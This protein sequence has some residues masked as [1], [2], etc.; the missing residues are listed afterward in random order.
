MKKRIAA[1]VALIA[2]LLSMP[3]CS[4]VDFD[5][6]GRLRA[7]HAVGDQSA[8]QAALE[9]HIFST[10]EEASGAYVL[11]YPKMGDYRSAFVMKDVTGDKNEEAIAFYALQPEGAK[12]HIALLSKVEG[13]WSC[14]DDVEGLAT[15]IERIQF[16]DLDADGVVELFAG[17]SMYNTRDR[18]LMMYTWEDNHFVERYSDTYTTMVVDKVISE[19]RDGLLLFRLNAKTSQT[20]VSL[21]TME[22]DTVK[23]LGTSALDGYILQFDRYQLATFENGTVGLFQDCTKDVRSKITEL[24]YWDGEQLVTPLYDP[25]ENINFVSARESSLPSMDI[26]GDGMIDFPQSYRLPGYELVETEDMN[27]WMSEWYTWDI[28]KTEIKPVMTNIMVPDDGYYIELPE[29]WLGNVTAEYDAEKRHLVVK[30]VVDGVI[31]D[32]LFDVVAF[33]TK[34]DNPFEDEDEYLFL[35]SNNKVRYE[36]SYEKENEYELS[37]DVLSELFNLCEIPGV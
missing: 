10:A 8:I 34:D 21:F 14:I 29:E 25:A 4:F 3:G 28:E 1:L 15:E 18:R 2:M 7:P 26:D 35:E 20:T 32:K 22:N 17:F 23:E 13:Q 19:K 9:Q 24:I 5:V 16:G 37:M 12:T 27:L 36:L 11:K 6:D 33:E 31:G 30:A